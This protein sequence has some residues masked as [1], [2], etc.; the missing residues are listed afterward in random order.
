LGGQS[1]RITFEKERF[2]EKTLLNTLI[3]IFFLGGL[4]GMGMGFIKVFGGGTP[5]EYG[6]MGG[7]GGFWLLSSAIVIFIRKRV[8]SA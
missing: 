3:V 7:V 8:E 5:A 1:S 6:I 2:M 4:F